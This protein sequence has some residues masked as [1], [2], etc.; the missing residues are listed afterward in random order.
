MLE[1]RMV[2]AGLLILVLAVVLLVRVTRMGDRLADLERTLAKLQRELQALRSAAG[3]TPAA[4]PAPAPPATPAASPVTRVAYEAITP[5]EL[6][7]AALAAA[8]EDAAREPAPPERNWQDLALSRQARP[9]AREAA[10]VRLV[11]EYFTGG[12]LVVRVGI[13]VLFFGVAF[14]LKYAAEHSRLP[15]EARLV[16]VALAAFGLF[17]LG[18]RQRS[19]RPGFSLSLQGGA[20]GVLYLTIFSAFRLYHL[21]PP[22]LAFAL[23]AV[24][25]VAS[26]L[27]A[28]KQDSLSF[29]ML[30]AAGGFLAPILASTGHGSHVALFSYYALLDLGIVALAWFKAWRPL[31]LLA[32][33]FTFGIG[34]FWGVTRYDPALFASTEPFLVFFFLAFVE[35]S[36]LFALRRAPQLTHYVDG[37]LVFGTPVVAMGLQ[38]GLVR[39]VPYGRAFSALAAA[40]AY[41]LLAAWLHRSRRASMRL[42]VESFLAL[43]I[44]LLT[45]AV[46]L[47]LDGHWTAATW[48]L[49]GTAILWMGL[50]QQRWLPCASGLLLQLGAGIAF[51]S[52]LGPHIGALPVLNAQ[53]LGALFIAAGGL[54]SAHIIRRASGA[55]QEWAPPLGVA[56]LAWGLLWWLYAGQHEIA[57]FLPGRWFGGALLSLFALTSVVAGACV[58]RLQ[59][60]ALRVP[61]LLILPALLL[62]AASWATVSPHPF[63]AAGWVG[64]P[65]GLVA[66][67]FA[68]RVHGSSLPPSLSQSMHLA[69]LWLLAVLAAW[70]LHWQV[71]AAVSGS[72]LWGTAAWGLAPAGLL[73]LLLQP[74]LALRWPIAAHRDAYLRWGGLGLALVLLLW[75]LWM[76]FAS[77]GTATPLPY[78]PL[79]NPLDIAEALVLLLVAGWLRAVWRDSPGFGP[80]LQR[81]LV[82]A[83]VLATFAWLNGVLLRSM[84]HWLAI[85]YEVDALLSS[86]DVQAALSIFWTLLAL[87]ATLWASRSARRIVWFGG[88]GLMAVVVAKL[89]LVDLARIGTVPRIISFLG[90]GVLM[91]VIGYFSPLPPAPKEPGR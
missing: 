36:I 56:L 89:F 54:V 48:A 11:R 67:L 35:I 5:E 21:L 59:W 77:D 75:S 57:T 37:T 74:A 4:M 78:V 39:D 29:A 40:A 65:L 10:L 63:G 23:L 86:T 17:A 82:A 1:P 49:E 50:R 7:A 16:G 28:L 27:L 20:I 55:M 9:P 30:G 61:A 24:L 69:S 66:L 41:L 64:W 31:N 90:V 72:S 6:E 51:A 46:P 73:L 53:C 62:A 83:L 47:A 44:A 42:L 81:V 33:V 34:T 26:G 32:F 91:L 13:I 14:L 18:W 85:P 70:E 12:N 79:L 84:H 8:P 38:F 60:P 52:H 22:G 15:I 3:S 58:R 19:K 45:L 88:A 80:D 71:N 68:L 43:G 2:A 87:G 25:G 76:N